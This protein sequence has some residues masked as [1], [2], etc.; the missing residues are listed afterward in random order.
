MARWFHS[1]QAKI[2]ILV[3]LMLSLGFGVSMLFTIE[4]QRRVLK[5]QMIERAKILASTLYKSIKSNMLE[6]RPDIARGLIKELKRLEDVKALQVFRN[7]GTEAFTD[8]RTLIKVQQ[9]GNLDEKVARKIRRAAAGHEKMDTLRNDPYFKKVLTTGKTIHWMEILANSKGRSVHVLTFLKPLENESDCQTCHGAK[10]KVQ[11]IVRVS[12]D[13]SGLE[14]QTSDLRNRQIGITLATLVIVS[15]A[16]VFF[17]RWTVIERLEVLASGAAK[18]GRGEFENIPEVSGNDEIA[19]LGQAFRNMTISL[20]SAYA[21]IQSKNFEL[22]NTLE[23]LKESRQ[24]IQLLENIKSQLA[25]FIPASVQRMLEDNPNAETL[26]KKD[27]DVTVLFLDIDGYTRM[28]ASYSQDIVNAV[29]EKYFSAFLDVVTGH[30]GD[31]NETAGDGLMVIFQDENDPKAHAA[32]AIDAAIKCVAGLPHSMM[33]ACRAIPSSS[34]TSAS[35]PAWP[36][37]APT[38]LSPR[39]GARAGHSRR[40]VWLP[41][42]PRESAALRPR[43]EFLSERKRGGGS[44][45]NTRSSIWA[46]TCSRT[47]PIRYKYIRSFRSA[48][49]FRKERSTPWTPWERPEKLHPVEILQGVR[50]VPRDSLEPD[51]GSGAELGHGE[52]WIKRP[53][54][55]EP[56]LNNVTAI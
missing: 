44:A 33:H 43:G 5:D 1:L 56:D 34:P 48:W 32:N 46:P 45:T 28:S 21:D 19:R 11:G 35:T 50:G 15:F 16:L 49:S 29:I 47:Y 20:K 40:A 2:L 6:G 26:E 38:N 8:L 3:I 23:E 27:K 41:T 17:L 51:L 37:W 12:T 54:V 18:I 53:W 10:S 4:V 9:S 24:K 25:K 7:D 14:A 13:V 22:E 30:G 42:S 36:R 55:F 52:L 31:I 39:V